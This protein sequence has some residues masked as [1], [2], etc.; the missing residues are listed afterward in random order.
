MGDINSRL[1]NEIT[2]EITRGD[3][4]LINRAIKAAIQE[5]KGYLAKFDLVAL[6]GIDAVPLDQSDPNAGTPPTVDD[7]FLKNLC[8]DIAV[9]TLVKLG[10]P[11]IQY[12]PA[13]EIYDAAI[14]TLKSIQKGTFQP[15]GWPYKDTTNETAPQG[16]AISYSSN[17][18][19]TPH[20]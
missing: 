9:W 8:V 10:N 7:L 17:T 1:Y 19:R 20:F 15:D 14:S 2:T 11:S 16:D 4:E 13:K 5:A 3:E 6:F 12:A 18:K